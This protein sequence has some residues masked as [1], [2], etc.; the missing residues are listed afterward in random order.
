MQSQSSLE[1]LCS[2][3]LLRCEWQSCPKIMVFS[4]GTSLLVTLL[5]F[6]LRSAPVSAVPTPQTLGSGLSIL[7]HNDLYGVSV[8]VPDRSIES[9]TRVK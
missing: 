3:N 2:L 6:F 1:F 5:A 4:V 9:S 7:T 8:V